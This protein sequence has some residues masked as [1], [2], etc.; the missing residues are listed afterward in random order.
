MSIYGYEDK[1]DLYYE[2]KEFLKNYPISELL[3]VVK[4]AVEQIEQ[5]AET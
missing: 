4:D 1:D 3:D 5:E 2:M